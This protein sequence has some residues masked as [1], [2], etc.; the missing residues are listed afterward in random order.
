MALCNVQMNLEQ[1]F[2][3]F[4]NN[5]DYFGFPKYKSKRRSRPSY[6]TN[7]INSNIRFESGR[8]RLPKLGLVKIV[9]HR[10]IP[11]GRRLKSVTVSRDAAGRYFAS[12]LYEH[13]DPVPAAVTPD[14]AK[15]L[16][17]D[18]SVPE[19]FADSDGNV[20]GKPR[21]YREAERKLAREQ[22]KL[23]RCRKGGKNRE[24]QRRK[25]GRRHA[26][27]ADTRKDFLNKLSGS[28][29]KTRD[30]VVIETLNV[31]AMSQGL[32]LGKSIHD[33]GWGMFRDMLRR[34][35]EGQGKRLVEVDRKFPSTKLC[36]ACGSEKTAMPLSERTYVCEAC[37]HVQDRDWNA[38]RNIRL[39]GLR[40]LVLGTNRGTRGDSLDADYGAWGR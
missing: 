21:H 5:A 14:P 24:K 32:R 18:F 25:V 3:N 22:R 15:V 20:A 10:P 1:A 17:L 16:G 11:E 19:L 23:S 2:R 30:A 33:A 6:T 36:S 34:K 37:G 40:L 31:G 38:A 27:V 35:L 13:S 4:F 7:F 26:K 12:M 28:I 39:E 8:L 9:R 29:A